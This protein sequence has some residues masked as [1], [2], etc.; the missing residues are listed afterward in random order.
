[1]H[2]GK[3]IGLL[4][5]SAITLLGCGVTATPVRGETALVP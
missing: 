4:G 1:M 3:L 5:L 2:Y